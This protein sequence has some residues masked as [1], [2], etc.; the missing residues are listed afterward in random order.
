MTWRRRAGRTRF[1]TC[2]VPNRK[3]A[4][5]GGHLI[6]THPNLVEPLLHTPWDYVPRAP[7][8]LQGFAEDLDL[9]S[10]KVDVCVGDLFGA[11]DLFVSRYMPPYE[12]YAAHILDE[13]FRQVLGYSA[14]SA[15]VSQNDGLPVWQG[16]AAAF[17]ALT[18]L[19]GDPMTVAIWE[20]QARDL[21]A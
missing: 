21:A 9:L 12:G 5:E 13:R 16:T 20:A 3:P 10:V 8:R 17:E 7:Y 14:R 2:P 15:A 11:V 19:V 18:P 6:E 4:C 1:C